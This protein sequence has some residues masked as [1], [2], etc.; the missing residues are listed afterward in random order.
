MTTMEKAG[1]NVVS[2][3]EPTQQKATQKELATTSIIIMSLINIMKC[4]IYPERLFWLLC[5]GMLD[6]SKGLL[7]WGYTQEVFQTLMEK[8]NRNMW[9]FQICSKSKKAFGFD[10]NR[11]GKCLKKVRTTTLCEDDGDGFE[12]ELEKIINL[13]RKYMGMK[14][15]SEGEDP[16]G[17]EGVTL[18]PRTRTVSGWIYHAINTQY[19]GCPI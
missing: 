12:S 19:S 15:T 8:E 4:D 14:L 17:P 1:A 6:S 9:F 16:F 7:K 13:W 3:K 18:L 5:S 2:P 10:L 11:L